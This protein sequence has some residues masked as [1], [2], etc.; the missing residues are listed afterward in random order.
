MW[1]PNDY[2]GF[3][4]YKA[5]IVCSF[6]IKSNIVNI[7]NYNFFWHRWIKIFMGIYDFKIILKRHVCNVNFNQYG[8]RN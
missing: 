8:I 2:R 3:L 6:I 1:N 7:E 4:S 5:V